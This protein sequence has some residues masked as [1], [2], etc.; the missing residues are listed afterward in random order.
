MCTTKQKDAPVIRTDNLNPDAKGSILYREDNQT[1]AESMLCTFLFTL[2]YITTSDYCSWCN[3]VLS[4]KTHKIT[5][6]LSNYRS[7]TKWQTWYDNRS[8]NSRFQLKQSW[9]QTKIDEIVV[10]PIIKC[11][12]N[13][14][15]SSNF[16]FLVVSSLNTKK[17]QR[18]KNNNYSN[19]VQTNLI[20]NQ[21][22]KEKTCKK[23]AKVCGGCFKSDNDSS[24]TVEWI[25]WVW[26]LSIMD[27]PYMYYFKTKCNTW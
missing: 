20:T 12:F 4:N 13:N 22:S 2:W 17:K 19:Y 10:I 8:F 1:T 27:V 3:N 25:Q 6:S 11:L 21:Y 15:G 5:H 23:D 24:E 26:F 14:A 18:W 16:S 7:K 9:E